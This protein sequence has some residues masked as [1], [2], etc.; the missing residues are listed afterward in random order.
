MRGKITDKVPMVGMFYLLGSTMHYVILPVDQ[1][2]R[3]DEYVSTNTTHVEWWHHHIFKI[4]KLQNPMFDMEDH[5]HV[6]RGRVIYNSETDI[7]ELILDKCIK[8]NKRLMT[9]IYETMSLP[10]KKTKV[11]LNFHYQCHKCRGE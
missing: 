9:E 1:G 5:E 10:R 2:D 8:K 11:V 7:Y 6:P 4:L 3:Q